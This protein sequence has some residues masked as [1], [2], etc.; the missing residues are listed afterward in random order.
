MV[1]VGSMIK[2][3]G[4]IKRTDEQWEADKALESELF[5][6]GYS[7]RRIRDKIN[8]RYKEMGIDIQISYQSVY[9]DIQKCLSEWKREQFTNIDQYVTQEIQALDNVAREAWRN[10]SV[11]NVLNAKLNIGLKRLLRCKRKLQRV[12]LRS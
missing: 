2:S 4:K 5:L 12:T 3:Q 11:L 7:Y 1:K 9:N 8:E 6:K 10:G